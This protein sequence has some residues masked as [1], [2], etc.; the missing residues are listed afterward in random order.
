MPLQL[1]LLADMFVSKSS[2]KITTQP[3]CD[4]LCCLPFSWAFEM[5]SKHAVLTPWW[6][7]CWSR[8]TP[9]LPGLSHWS[10]LHLPTF[11]WPMQYWADSSGDEPV[12]SSDLLYSS[13][14]VCIFHV[15]IICCGTFFFSIFISILQHHAVFRDHGCCHGCCAWRTRSCKTWIRWTCIWNRRIC[16]IRF[17]LSHP[18]KNTIGTFLG[19]HAVTLLTCQTCMP[20]KTTK[21]HQ[22]ISNAI[23]VFF[24]HVHFSICSLDKGIE[25]PYQLIMIGSLCIDGFSVF[26]HVGIS[27]CQLSFIVAQTHIEPFP[28]PPSCACKTNPQHEK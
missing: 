12:W 11:R 1:D 9:K 8:L 19:K 20:D 13:A 27:F 17:M 15:L 24:Q 16:H 21:V 23:N 5:L 3:P 18:E 4:L 22:A 10:H 25:L 6:V 2:K 7:L 28:K 14:R 26:P